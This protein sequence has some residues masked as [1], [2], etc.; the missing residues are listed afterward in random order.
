MTG[1][2]CRLV[3]GLESTCDETGAALVD[4]EGFILSNAV[5]TQ[6]D[7]HQTFGGV[8]PELASRA[9]TRNLIPVL[10]AAFERAGRRPGEVDAVAVAN[11]PGL[12]GSLLT[13]V[14]AAQTLAWSLNVPLLA[15]DHV[16]AHLTAVNLQPTLDLH[17]DPTGSA[18]RER[19]VWAG[20]ASRPALGLV[21]SGGHTA[22]YRVADLLSPQRL[23]GTIDDAAG[24][25]FDKAAVVLGL[26]HP[27]GPNLDRAARRHEA[28]L[29]AGGAAEVGV[30]LPR[31]L[32][33]RDS[34]DLSFSGLKTAMLY[35]V[36]GRPVG[37]GRE[38]RFL[39]DHTHLDAAEVDAYAHAFETAVVEV[40]LVKLRRAAAA[41]Q[42]TPRTLIVGG[43]VSANTQLRRRLATLAEEL[44]LSLRLPDM[45]V[46]V[47]NAAMIAGQGLV[48]L[49]SGRLVRGPERLTVQA[50]PTGAAG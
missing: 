30:K 7:I 43:G 49:G 47:D 40:L 1:A 25:A 18:V 26:G 41:I 12:V 31:S 8:V 6:H 32:L 13:G 23:G 38:S 42:P 20:D 37:R 9:H 17:R 33:S 15:V 48:H 27:G 34:L 10:D 36:R 39:R 19:D 5:A 46:C 11:R 21:V 2:A 35:A 29:H 14:A 4:A 45:A 28:A 24:E 50:M 3:L 22:V 44:H 16:H